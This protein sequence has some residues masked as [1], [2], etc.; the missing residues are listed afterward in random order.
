[1]SKD[2]VTMLY[3][4]TYLLHYYKIGDFQKY[5]CFQNDDILEEMSTVHKAT[6]SEK[7]APVNKSEVCYSNYVTEQHQYEKKTFSP[8]VVA[9]PSALSV[10][11]SDI[12]QN[13]GEDQR[14]FA[15]N[16]YIL[17]EIGSHGEDL[18]YNEQLSRTT[19]ITALVKIMKKISLN[20]LLLPQVLESLVLQKHLQ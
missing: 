9:G 5:Y 18:S 17:T 19:S 4:V 15:V 13:Q 3:N 1:M 20:R 16:D 6:V 11:P 10:K 12:I 2:I 8:E 14:P 7:H